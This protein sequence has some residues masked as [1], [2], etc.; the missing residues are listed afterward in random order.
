MSPA[1]FALVMATGIVSIAALEFDLPVL[2]KALFV[3]NAVAYVVL[4]ALT[5]VRATRFWPQFI[6]DLTDHRLAAGFFTTVAGSCI[7]GAQFRLIAGNVNAATAFLILGIVLWAVITYIVFT[8]LTIK[9][10]KP[11]LQ[12]GITGAWLIAV[13]ATQ[14]IAVLSALIA[15]DLAQPHRLELNF[16]ALSMWLWGGMFYIWIISL[17]FY[18]YLFFAFSPGDLTPPSW[19]TMG[20]MAIST[21][22]G[23]SLVQNTV[24]A[25]FLLSLLPFLKGFTVFYWATGMWWIP[26]LVVLGIWRYFIK[27]FPLRYSPLYWGAV[28]P[29]G[30]YSVATKQMSLALG[31][32]FLA[33]LPSA[34]FIAALIA[35]T[36]TFAGLLLDLRKMLKP[37]LV[38][39]LMLAVPLQA[40]RVRAADDMQSLT[41]IWSAT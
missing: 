17:I 4:V 7:I 30:M 3:L 19:I 23:S 27:R 9:A 34:F 31:L 1:Y 36:M 13:V 35:W 5:F 39:V 33:P 32:P 6:A 18:R 21:L 29:L 16:F 10:E 25:P 41:G 11:P 40:V 15:R 28:F 37:T 22:A 38:A 26:M 14:S 24:D 2:A 12:E 8:A 20:A